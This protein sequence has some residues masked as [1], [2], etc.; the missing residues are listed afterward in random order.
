MWALVSFLV[1][2]LDWALA[3][4]DFFRSLSPKYRQQK[5]EEKEQ[6]EEDDIYGP[7]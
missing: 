6:Q 2:L 7:E 4:R 5:R 1:R 3:I